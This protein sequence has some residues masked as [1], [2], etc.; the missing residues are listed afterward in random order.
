VIAP[1]MP[2]RIT[3]TAVSAGNPPRRSA[4]LGSE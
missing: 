1:K 2:V 3:T 4:Q